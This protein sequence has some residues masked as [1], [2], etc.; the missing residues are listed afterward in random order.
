MDFGLSPSVSLQISEL[1][2]D[3]EPVWVSHAGAS[4]THTIKTS[5]EMCIEEFVSLST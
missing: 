4:D 3:E 1:D 2:T 5:V